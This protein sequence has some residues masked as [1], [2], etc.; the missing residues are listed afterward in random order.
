MSVEKVKRQSIEDLEASKKA[1]RAEKFRLVDQPDF[2]GSDELLIQM[3]DWERL[4]REGKPAISDE[5]WDSLVKENDY[6]E[7]LDGM[8]SP[9]GRRW[10]KLSAPLGSLNKR[11]TYE[12]AEAF[13]DKMVSIGKDR[14]IVEPKFDGLTFSMFFAKQDDGSYE[15]FAISSRGDGLQGLELFPD[16]MYGIKA[17]G[18]PDSIDAETCKFLEENDCA[19]DG[20]IE[21]RGEAVINRKIY[22]VAG[23]DKGYNDI[24][25]RSIAAGM[26]NRKWPLNEPYFI[27]QY[28]AVEDEKEMVKF[29]NLWGLVGR[30]KPYAEI[31]VL[32]P[33]ELEVFEEENDILSFEETANTY[34]GY[35]QKDPSSYKVLG[36]LAGDGSWYDLS[37]ADASHK[38]KIKDEYLDFIAFSIASKNGN[39]DNPD[40]LYKV[41]GLLCVGDISDFAGVYAYGADK[42]STLKSIDT[43]YGTEK[44]VRKYDLVRVKKYA[45]YAADGVVI[46]PID[47]DTA[48]Q[49]ME[50]YHK[51]NGQIVVPKYPADQ[52]AVKLETDPVTTKI[53]KIIQKETNLKNK[54]VSAEI[55]PTLVESG[56]IVKTVNL[57][58]PNYLE[59]NKD[60]IYEGAEVDLI[61]SG[62]IIPVFKRRKDI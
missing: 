5:E 62:D 46:K 33:E 3:Q 53:L 27:K 37:N 41:K 40:I 10:I 61:M 19:M 11:Y 50:P 12:E 45:A 54:T 29:L 24:V 52:L 23:T 7:S 18:L 9:N 36:K 51:P 1:N 48:S 59:L 17:K 22:S 43:F 32:S 13:I 60:W 21:I 31:K 20:I 28:F 56:A 25:A 35:E 39:I 2:K 49:A 26:F 34:D 30:G 42:D 57:H 4:Y 14:F 44:G 15:R 16:A 38:G 6:I 55:V 47:S 8:L 58:N